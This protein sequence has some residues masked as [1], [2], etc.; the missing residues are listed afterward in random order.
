[1]ISQAELAWLLRHGGGQRPASEAVTSPV[2]AG[3]EFP[4]RRLLCSGSCKYQNE[5][6]KESKVRW[7][8]PKSAR[9]ANENF[10]EVDKAECLTIILE[11]QA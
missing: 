9:S 10:A 11:R 4:P 3:A 2:A 6:S 5:H 8:L 1:M 7:H